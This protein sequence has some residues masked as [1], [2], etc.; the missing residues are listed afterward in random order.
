MPKLKENSVADQIMKK[1][2]WTLPVYAEQRGLKK[3]SLIGRYYSIR[4]RL[5]LEEDG[6]DLQKAGIEIKSQEEVLHNASN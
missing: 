5:I 1:F 6:I 4:T 2:G 3:S